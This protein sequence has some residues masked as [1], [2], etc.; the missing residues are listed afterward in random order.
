MKFPRISAIHTI[1]HFLSDPTK[2]ILLLDG[3]RFAGKSTLLQHIYTSTEIW[4]GKKYYYSFADTFGGKQFH[5][6]AEFVQYMQIK[7]GL[8]MTQP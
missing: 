3:P 5:D 2:S 7:H 4:K 6:A 1:E 8:D